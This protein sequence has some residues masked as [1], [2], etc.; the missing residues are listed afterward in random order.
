MKNVKRIFVCSLALMVSLVQLA[1]FQV[2]ASFIPPFEVVS[3]SVYMVNTDTGTVLYEKNADKQTYPASLT[4]IMTAIIALEQVPDLEGTVVTAPA[5]I[6]DELYLSGASTADIRQFEEVRMIDL[7]YAMMLP[8]ACEAS[9][10]IADYVGKGSIPDF[11]E[12]MNQKAKAIGAVNTNFTNAHGLFHEDQ[13]TTAYDMYLIAE[14]AMS[15]PMFEKITNNASYLM[16]A[17]NK[18]AE[19]RYITN[20]N[21]MLSEYRGGAYYYKD[22]KAIKTGAL[23]EIGKNLI[24]SVSR[25][26]YNYTLVTIGAPTTNK[27]GEP[28]GINMSFD[29]AKSLYD[30]ALSTF[31]H[32]K[33]L[34]EHETIDEIPVS[35]SSQQDYVTLIAQEDVIAL[36]PSNVDPSAVQQIITSIDNITAPVAQ[37]DVLGTVELKL[38]DDTIAVVNLTAKEDI[39]RNQILYI[40]DIIKRFLLKP[41]TI[42]LLIILGLLVITYLLVLLR[43]RKLKRLRASRSRNNMKNY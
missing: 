24:T 7:L 40:L 20:T 12:M 6:F 3:D 30:W 25:N 41:S 29:D 14:Y 8:S 42:T 15:I 19:E 13:I 11:I 34:I 16:P 39:S 32:Q 26:G 38:A 43:F 4:K 2:D 22:M 31:S 37:G 33:V 5:Y 28:Y 23:P 9:S 21:I 17:T 10:I 35:L 18:H 36:L 1:C 27:E